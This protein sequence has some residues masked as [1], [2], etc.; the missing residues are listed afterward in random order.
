MAQPPTVIVSGGGLRS[1][2]ATALTLSE[3]DPQ[4]IV[5]VH[6]HDGRANAGQRA[7][8]M[9]LQAARYRINRLVDIDL[10]YLQS[11]PFV[12]VNQDGGAS[13]LIRPQ[14]LLVALGQA[15]RLKAQRLIWP[16][17]INADYPT[18]ARAT[19]EVVLVEQLVKLEQ[20]QTP[21]I[22]MPLLDLTDQQML[23]LA[24]QLDAPFELAWSCMMA[25]ERPCGVCAACQHRHAAF[26]SAGM[27]D[28]AEKQPALR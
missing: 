7:E 26:E 2:T 27:I 20:Q 6:L 10:P 28:P 12:P 4:D 22:D 11:T 14:T 17:Q 16:V 19:E 8:H 21:A 23:E 9:R 24:G 5:L 13:P 3:A 15:I 1:L 25:Q 18:V